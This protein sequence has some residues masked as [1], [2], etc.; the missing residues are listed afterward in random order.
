MMAR[1]PGNCHEGWIDVGVGYSG[2]SRDG[3]GAAEKVSGE[4]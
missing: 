3:D 4:V 2:R 1:S